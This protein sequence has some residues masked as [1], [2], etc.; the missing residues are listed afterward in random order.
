MWVQSLGQED[1]LKEGMAHSSII[2]WTRMDRGTWQA[3]VPRVAK[4]Q[5]G[6]KRLSTHTHRHLGRGQVTL[7]YEGQSLIKKITSHILHD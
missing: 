2:A 7:Q 6:L 4:C 1:P 5:T 3:T